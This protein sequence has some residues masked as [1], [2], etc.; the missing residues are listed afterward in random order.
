[1]TARGAT[2]TVLRGTTIAGRAS[3]IVLREITIVLRVSTIDPAATMTETIRATSIEG[4]E[5]LIVTVHDPP[6]S[7]VA[8]RRIG[9]VASR[10]E[11]AAAIA[12]DGRA[13]PT[14]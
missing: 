5:T 1:M 11:V 13:E 14:S 6:G 12:R 8:A 10:A 9:G 7:R 3:S 4:R 2:T